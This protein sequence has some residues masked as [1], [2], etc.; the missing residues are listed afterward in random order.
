LN[1]KQ[2]NTGT[3]VEL[4]FDFYTDLKVPLALS[5]EIYFFKIFIATKKLKKSFKKKEQKEKNKG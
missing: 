1:L 3:L 2:V 4:K 5:A